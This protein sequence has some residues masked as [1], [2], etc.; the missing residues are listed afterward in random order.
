MLGSSKLLD[1]LCCT[2][3]RREGSGC[4]NGLAIEQAVSWNSVVAA[5][6]KETMKSFRFSHPNSY[7]KM[8]NVILDLVPATHQYT[9]HDSAHAT[10][11]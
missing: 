9:H 3:D 8:R 11:P 7:S 4:D 2:G 10:G 5:M 1:A 6:E